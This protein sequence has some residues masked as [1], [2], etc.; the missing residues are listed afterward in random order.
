MLSPVVAPL[1][2]RH[3][4]SVRLL[5]WKRQQW[6]HHRVHGHCSMGAECV[7]SKDIAN[8]Y[9]QLMLTSVGPCL[10]IVRLPR[11]YP[12]QPKSMRRVRTLLLTTACTHTSP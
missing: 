1:V 5:G 9:F 4:S 8:H 7:V 11:A 2:A 3:T 12:N 6:Q 10:L